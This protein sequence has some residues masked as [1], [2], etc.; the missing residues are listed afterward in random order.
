MKTGIANLPLHWGQAPSW[1]FDRMTKLARSIVIAIVSEFGPEEMLLRLSNPYWF[2]SMGCLLG[3]DW[4]SSGL[5]TTLCGA[6]KEGIKDIQKDFG[7][8]IA[9]GKGAT[10]R[11]TP[12]EITEIAQKGLINTNA[13]KLIYASRMSAK[14]DNSAIQ[15]GFQ[16]YQH[17]FIFT[18]EGK[19]GAVQQEM[20]PKTGWAIRYHWYSEAIRDFV[21]EPHSAI[22]SQQRVK[23]LNMVAK[24]SKESREAS[25][26]VACKNPQILITKVKRLQNL[27]LPLN[28]EITLK[29]INPDWLNKVL[30]KTYKKT[31]RRF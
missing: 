31:T 5:T 25:I 12:N 23:S 4:H 13:S 3:F 6:L 17:V 9:G 15:D 8:F 27:D 26:F 11:K 20:N 19:W 7:L 28:H 2:Q 14:V 16:I 1:L 18:K 22:C 29:E 10:S 24:E 30:L 21:C